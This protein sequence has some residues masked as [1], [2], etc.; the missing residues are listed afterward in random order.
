MNNNENQINSSDSNVGV[1][2]ATTNLNTAIENPN[3]DVDSATG[4]NIQNNQ[5]SSTFDNSYLNSS[6]LEVNSN[7]ISSFDNNNNLGFNNNNDLVDNNFNANENVSVNTGGYAKVVDQNNAWLN[8]DNSNSS[9]SNGVSE[10]VN[11]EPIYE[12]KEVKLDSKENAFSSKELKLI[13][14]IAFLL[15]VFILILPYLYDFFHKIILAI[16]NSG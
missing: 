13:I 6:N 2:K 5:F 8:D 16:V 10:D 1:Y 11:Y 7:N 12:K 3:I 4:I 9:F 15:I 14:F